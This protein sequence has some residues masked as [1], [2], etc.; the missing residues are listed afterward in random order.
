M[1]SLSG[2]DR[3][4]DYQESQT[5]YLKHFT[6]PPFFSIVN[7]NAYTNTLKYVEG[8]TCHCL[9]FVMISVFI[10][11][12]VWVYMHAYTGYPKRNHPISKPYIS[13]YLC[14]SVN[15][16]LYLDKGDV[17]NYCS[18]KLNS[19]AIITRAKTLAHNSTQY[20]TFSVLESRCVLLYNFGVCCFV[21][22]FFTDSN[23]NMHC[24]KNLVNFSVK[25][26]HPFCPQITVKITVY[27]KNYNSIKT[28]KNIYIWWVITKIVNLKRIKKHLRTF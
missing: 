4:C 20:H 27:C 3:K 8:I 12:Q 21:S 24:K 6:P 22:F 9:C 16:T 26:G 11:L 13:R 28:R 14:R 7:A 5:A 15:L 18:N 2:G 1:W 25:Y 19:L 10:R 23:T 17:G